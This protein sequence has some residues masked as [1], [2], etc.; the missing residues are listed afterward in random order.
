MCIVSFTHQ[1]SLLQGKE[2]SLTE[3]EA[4]LFLELFWAGFVRKKIC[5]SA[6]NRTLAI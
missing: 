4:G 2:L 5:T 1:P 3:W 6:G